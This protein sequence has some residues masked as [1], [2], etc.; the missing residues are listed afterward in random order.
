[1]TADIVDIAGRLLSLGKIT[2]PP[3]NSGNGALEV[4]TDY[5]TRVHP[6]RVMARLLVDDFEGLDVLPDPDHFLAWLWEKGF[7]IVSVDPLNTD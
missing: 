2:E 4:V 3:N 7:K 5:L 1:M 6:A